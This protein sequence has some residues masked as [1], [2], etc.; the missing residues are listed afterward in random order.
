MAGPHISINVKP[1]A[2]PTRRLTART[3]PQAMNRDANAQIKNGIITKVDHPT[4]WALPRSPT[5]GRLVTYFTNLNTHVNRPVY[6][7]PCFR[8]ILQDMPPLAKP[9][10]KGVCQAR[11]R[12]GIFPDRPGRGL[13]RPHYVPEAGFLVPTT[14]LLSSY[15]QAMH[16][17]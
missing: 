4:N 13:S 7:F 6:P 3:I 1:D 17:L 12:A 10:G 2:K 9:L 14:K 11:R 5:G 8:E 15:A 16:E